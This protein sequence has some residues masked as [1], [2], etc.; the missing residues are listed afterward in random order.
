MLICQ[1]PAIQHILYG[2]N[3]PI[4]KVSQPET[5]AGIH[6]LN[7]NIIDYYSATAKLKRAKEDQVNCGPK[8]N[9][10]TVTAAGLSCPTSISYTCIPHLGGFVIVPTSAAAVKQSKPN[11]GS[12]LSNLASRLKQESPAGVNVVASTAVVSSLL[13]N[14]SS[15][16]ENTSGELFVDDFGCVAETVIQTSDTYQ[17][18]DAQPST[19]TRPA[20]MAEIGN[21]F[22]LQVP[23]CAAN[24]SLE[25]QM[26]EA[27]PGQ[28]CP[29]C[30][31]RIS[32]RHLF[33]VIF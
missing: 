32:G 9:K 2:L 25:S 4:K 19:P 27:S 11:A 1:A 18:S 7:H 8:E 6:I 14:G 22:V 24:C 17:V 33:K 30:G 16:V 20:Q 31:D 3:E 15:V 28:G 26:T 13:S 12:M 23:P 5:G 29:I 21:S 10:L